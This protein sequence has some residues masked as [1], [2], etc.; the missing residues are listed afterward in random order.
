M[1][2]TILIRQH[3]PLIHFQHNAAGAFLRGT[4]VKPALDRYIAKRYASAHQETPNIPGHWKIGGGHNDVDAL[5]YK[6][7]FIA[8]GQESYT[9]NPGGNQ[10]RYP[11][12]FGDMGDEVTDREFL[13]T[14]KDVTVEIMSF[15]P[16]LLD[17]VHR[18]L[19][20]FFSRHNFMMRKTKGFGSF[21]AL[22]ADGQNLI[23]GGAKYF[24]LPLGPSS[25]PAVWKKLFTAIDYFYR[26]I[27]S[28]MNLKSRD[29]DALYFKSLMFQYAQ[30]QE[31]HQWDKRE[32]RRHIF[33]RHPKF[34]EIDRHRG[35]PNDPNSTFNARGGQAYLYRDMLG[36]AS[37][38]MWYFYDR[39]NVKKESDQVARFASPITFKPVFLGGQKFRVYLIANPVP[40]EMLG[41]RF[42]VSATGRGINRDDL[43][44]TTPPAFNTTHYLNFVAGFFSRNG[45]FSE[46]DFEDYV[47]DYDQRPNIREIVDTLRNIYS[48]LSEQA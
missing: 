14:S 39:A 43:F 11:A 18:K 44:M 9:I 20:G 23:P 42:K 16:D 3:T 34:Q 2:R 48:Q 27:R 13:Y 35:G 36:L 29:G 21:T 32:M 19:G 45:R 33:G 31:G 26:T 25:N 8:E 15:H 46:N 5:N 6:I 30:Q 22:N 41:R 37:D 38:S 12:Y 7:K 17:F 40:E 28:G 47:G 24:D 1:K 10:G 4:E